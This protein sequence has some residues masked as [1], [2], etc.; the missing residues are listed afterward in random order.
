MI[1]PSSP[2]GAR[3]SQTVLSYAWKFSDLSIG[4]VRSIM[5]LDFVVH[6]LKTP[7]SF[8]KMAK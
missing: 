6:I 3:T 2:I 5:K 4:N 1:L 8:W 7:I